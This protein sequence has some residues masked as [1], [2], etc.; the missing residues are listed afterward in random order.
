[1]KEKEQCEPK[2]HFWCERRSREDGITGKKATQFPG[3]FIG[4]VGKRIVAALN[5]MKG[6]R[7]LEK[8]KKGKKALLWVKGQLADIGGRA[9]Y[10]CRCLGGKKN[11]QFWREGGKGTDNNKNLSC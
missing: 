5:V 8:S 10:L 2:F 4:C 3:V 1:M 6:R 11:G 9:H 7:G